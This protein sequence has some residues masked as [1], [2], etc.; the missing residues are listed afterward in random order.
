MSMTRSLN[1]SIARL[2]ACVLL[3]AQLAVSAYACP[4]LATMSPRIAMTDVGVAADGA[5]IDSD[6]SAM[7]GCTGMG[8]LDQES[9][10]LCAEHCKVGQ[11]S[12]EVPG[13]AVPLPLLT[14]LYAVPLTPIEGP[15]PR[16]TAARIDALVAASPP[17]AVLL[18]VYRI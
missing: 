1:R 3:L 18:C 2:L 15:P 16:P 10:N 5:S 9:A 4:S 6:A 14:A 8:A 13:V 11:Q 12:H 7:P 17:L